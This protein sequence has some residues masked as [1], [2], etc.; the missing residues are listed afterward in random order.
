[1]LNPIDFKV[2]CSAIGTIMSGYRDE[3]LTDAQKALLQELRARRAGTYLTATGKKG[4]Y[5]ATNEAALGDLEQ[6]EN[7]PVVL[8][9]TPKSY[10]QTWAKEQVYDVQKEFTTKHTQ[11]GNMVEA[12]GI[13]LL[14]RVLNRP[15]MAPYEGPRRE[16]DY[17]TGTCDVEEPDLILD[18]KAPWDCFT[19]P[20]FIDEGYESDYRDQL[21]GYCD[22]YQ[23]PLGVLAYVLLDAPDEIVEREAYRTMRYAGL[24]EMS[25][26]IYEATKKR[27][28]FS[29]MPDR[30]RVRLFRFAADADRVRQV[31]TQ[32]ERCRDYLKE[33]L[34]LPAMEMRNL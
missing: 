22:L 14:R 19:H 3:A 16:D 23:R 34:E 27:L 4:G 11:K 15:F 6:R 33:I 20:L 31:H 32:V 25:D 17:K 26:E 9:Q 29:H 30:F 7:E 28:T 13:D 5:S 1:M 12:E 2:R 24:S 18:H 8:T 21:I 10:V